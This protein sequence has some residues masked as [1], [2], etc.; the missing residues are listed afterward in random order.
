MLN[1]SV[2]ESFNLEIHR[3][4]RVVSLFALRSAKGDR[5]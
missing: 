4:P 3:E 1:D 2:A 5:S